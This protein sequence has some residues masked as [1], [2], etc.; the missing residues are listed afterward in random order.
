M[1]QRCDA[2]LMVIRDGFRVSEV[3]IRFQVSR[4]TPYSWTI[5]YEAGGTEGFKDRSHRSLHMSHQLDGERAA[6]VIDQMK[7]W[8][9][10]VRRP[11]WTQ[12]STFGLT[13]LSSW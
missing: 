9:L 5:D 2:V 8:T 7:V 12:E 11:S 13:P 10:L 1:E 3:A 4:Q 6:A